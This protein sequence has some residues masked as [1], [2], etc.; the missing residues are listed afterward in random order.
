[1]EFFVWRSDCFNFIEK[2][3]RAE[4]RLFFFLYNFMRT[5]IGVYTDNFVLREKRCYDIFT[6]T[7]K[8]RQERVL[9]YIAE[10]ST[11]F[12]FNKVEI[13][14]EDREIYTYG[15]EL[16]WSTFFSLSSMLIL[17]VI[18]GYVP[19][20]VVFTLFFLPI[21]MTAGGAHASS[22]RN[23]WC[24]SNLV[25]IGCVAAGNWLD[26][27]QPPLL[28]S[29]ALLIVALGYVWREAPVRL[30]GESQRE[31]IIERNRR[32]SHVILV[33]EAVVLIIFQGSGN[34]RMYYTAAIAS[35]IVAIM[36]W[37]AIKGER[38]KRHE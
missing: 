26:R 17:A 25:G 30:A 34:G 18:F 31:Q 8:E 16:F 32:Y 15:F 6:E 10:K 9:Q 12:L 33:I 29:F 21:R 37:I 4:I 1:M 38:R 24:L 7:K 3:E 27:L 13:E 11:D 36:I 19:Q 5:E 2:E 22:Y 20:I 28:I 35:Y 14:S 23:C